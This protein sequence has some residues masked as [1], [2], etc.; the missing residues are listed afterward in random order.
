M[1]NSKMGEIGT[2]LLGFFKALA[3]ANRLKIIGLLAQ[4]EYAVE[5]IAEMLNLSPSTVSHH[6]SKLSSAGLVSARSESYYNTYHLETGILESMS[7]R[8]LARETMPAV[9]ADVNMDAYDRK[10]LNTFCDTE[11]RILQFPAQRKKFEVL[12]R[13]VVKAFKPEVHYKE[14]EV[15]EILSSY[16]EDTATL[17][18]GL[19]EHG[20]AI[21]YIPLI[22][23]HPSVDYDCYGQC[24]YLNQNQP[25]P[26]CSHISSALLILLF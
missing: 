20:I 11:G 9:T 13:Y 21:D 10:V 8:L 12:L 15:N 7:Q 17:R 3:D 14:K 23:S 24:Q 22:V 4:G 1:K 25:V 6:L 26:G 5:Q 18:R 16:S 19:V 2:E